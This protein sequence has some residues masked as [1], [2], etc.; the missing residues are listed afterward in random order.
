MKLLGPVQ[1]N[2]GNFF[3]WVSDQLVSSPWAK[4]TISIEIYLLVEFLS[5]KCVPYLFGNLRTRARK[6]L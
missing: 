3:V 1:L 2:T 5:Y 4:K 6:K